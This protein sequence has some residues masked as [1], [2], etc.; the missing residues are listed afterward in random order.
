MLA[1]H[2]YIVSFSGTMSRSIFK[3][4][5]FNSCSVKKRKPRSNGPGLGVKTKSKKVVPIE[6]WHFDEIEPLL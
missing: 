6:A 3:F 2:D 4:F 1:V 5:Q